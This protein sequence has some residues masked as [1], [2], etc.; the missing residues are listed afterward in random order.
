MSGGESVASCSGEEEGKI[1]TLL[2]ATGRWVAGVVLFGWHYGFRGD[3]RCT[4]NDEEREDA[5][6]SRI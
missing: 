6:F 2:C 3:E 1:C 5:R 4:L